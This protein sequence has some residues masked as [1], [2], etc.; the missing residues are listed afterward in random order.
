M[1]RPRASGTLLL[2]LISLALPGAALAGSPAEE[3]VHTV[4]SGET[5]AGVAARAVVP[6]VLIIEANGLKAPYTLR[7]GQKLVIPRRRSHTVETGETGF[8]IAMH[9]GLTWQS[10]AVANGLDPKKPL[11]AGTTLAIP[12]LSKL[13]API[14]GPEGSQPPRGS[15]ADAPNVDTELGVRFAWPAPG[16]LLRSFVPAGKA[17]AHSGIDLAG[18]EG[19]AVR[20]VA[21]GRVI[22]AG[23]E[24]SRYGNLVIIDH[25]NGWASAYAKLQK[26]TVK[27]GEKVRAGERVGLL[28]NT[29]ETS[30]TALH[31]EI[32]RKNKPLDPELVLAPR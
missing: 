16:R 9:Y 11:K 25:G 28:G 21:K 8:E 22:F 6:R 18:A 31:F 20:A 23:N 10:I 29:G 1:R 12:T 14:A 4:K 27:K 32:R 24:P 7:A 15:K 26:V 19:S 17:G 30:D 5:L 3:T 2:A 13:P